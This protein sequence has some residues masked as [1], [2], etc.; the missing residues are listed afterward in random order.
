[1]SAFAV[2]PLLHLAL[3]CGTLQWLEKGSIHFHCLTGDAHGRSILL[4]GSAIAFLQQVHT[5]QPAR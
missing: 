3:S 4:H 5:R 2:K 1:V